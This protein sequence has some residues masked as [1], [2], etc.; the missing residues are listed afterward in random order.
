VKIILYNEER[1]EME[2]VIYKNNSAL[3]NTYRI[4][5]PNET[6]YQLKKAAVIGGTYGLI[7]YA[8]VKIG[9]KILE[10]SD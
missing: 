5:L 6:K 8:T 7:F 9:N 1:K 4:A 10:K 2:F 3:S